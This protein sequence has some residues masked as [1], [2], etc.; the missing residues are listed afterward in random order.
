MKAIFTTANYFLLVYAVYL[1]LICNFENYIHKDFPSSVLLNIITG[2]FLIIVGLY[3]LIKLTKMHRLIGAV[4]VLL[5]LY[6]S[7]L[8]LDDL[9]HL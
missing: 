8:L 6:I 2:P 5:G 7:Y 9:N 3:S 1:L 4:S